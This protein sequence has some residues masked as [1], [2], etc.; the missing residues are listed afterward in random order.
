MI[1]SALAVALLPAFAAAQTVHT[2][3]VAPESSFS[4]SPNTVTGAQAG[5]IVNFVFETAYVPSYF[6]C[7]EL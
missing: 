1:Y 6:R 5:D 3:Q 4:Y 7:P 2:V